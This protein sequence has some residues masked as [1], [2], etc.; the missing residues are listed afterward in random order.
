MSKPMRYLSNK[1]DKSYYFMVKIGRKNKF[2]NKL[3]QE[4]C[5]LKDEVTIEKNKKR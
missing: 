2:T 5:S 4:K 1:D 3:I